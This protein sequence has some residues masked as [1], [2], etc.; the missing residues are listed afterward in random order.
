MGRITDRRS[1]HADEPSSGDDVF[2]SHVRLPADDGKKS[3]GEAGRN[4]GTRYNTGTT[5][6]NTGT[7][8]Q[9]NTEHYWYGTILV[10]HGTILV[11]YNTGTTWYNTGTVQ[12][13][14]NMIQ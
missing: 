5:W 8:Q 3:H 12:Y 4:V 10:Q 9:Y 2:F 11:R 14:Y 1:T 6:Y 13:W 7:I